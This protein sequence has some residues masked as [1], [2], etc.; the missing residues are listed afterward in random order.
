VHRRGR[1]VPG[2]S[3][4][5]LAIGVRK[6]E[7]GFRPRIFCIE[8]HS[9][10][11]GYYGLHK[12]IGANCM[13]DSTAILVLGM[14][15]SGTS[16]TA[17]WLHALGVNLGPYL[18]AED[19]TQPK[20]YF[21][22]AEIVGIHNDLM[23]AF[24]SSWDDPR[25]LPEGWEHDHRVRFFREQL[26]EIVRRD[27]MTQPLWG[28]K[29]PRLCRLLPLWLAILGELGVAVRAIYVLRHPAEVAESLALRNG[30]SAEKSG[31]LWLRHVLEAERHSRWVPRITLRYGDLLRDWRGESERIAQALGIVWPR[32]Y[33]EVAAA[34]TGFLERGLRHHESVYFDRFVPPLRRWI[35]AA[36]RALKAGSSTSEDAQ[37][38]LDSVHRELAPYDSYVAACWLERVR[39][40]S[41][42]NAHIRAVLT[43]IQAQLSHSLADVTKARSDSELARSALADAKA[44]LA[45]AQSELTA[46]RAE[47][48]Q[49]I[50]GLASATAQL[51][52][53]HS[54]LARAR[55]EMVQEIAATRAELTHAQGDLT[56][57]RTASTQVS[58]QLTQTQTELAQ[59]RGELDRSRG[60]SQRAHQE[61]EAIYRSRYWRMTRPWRTFDTYLRNRR[62]CRR[63]KRR[64]AKALK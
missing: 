25:P 52:E 35:V 39:N 38:I 49:K 4:V 15:R 13:A 47:L 20:G 24:D 28:A 5:A 58:A 60:D 46:A 17:G 56:D 2:E 55:T 16:A 23:T 9:T 64:R 32:P 12:T 18:M 53:A 19:P 50:G 41:L 11:S 6:Q 3:A 61:L 10:F 57:V 27:L 26:M 59:A 21:E 33:D 29:D 31:L 43:Q 63:E 8:P 7:A 48:D 62:R 22:H 36:Y 34:V 54:E 1:F 51:A 45:Q 14:H 40:I 30:F 42:E 37:A 44:E